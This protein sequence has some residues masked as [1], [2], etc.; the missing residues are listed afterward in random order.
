[1]KTLTY[2][3]FLSFCFFAMCIVGN[4]QTIQMEDVGGVYKI[5][6]IVNGLR[7]KMIFDPGASTVCI[8]ES[9]AVMMLE[10]EYLSINDIKGTGQSQVADGSIV[11][12][13]KIN[14]KKVQIGDKVLNNIEAVVIHGQDAPLLFGQSALR[15]LGQY[16]ISGNKLIIGTSDGGKE[17]ALTQKEIDSI[18]SIA[19]DAA[20]KGYYNVA[21]EQYKILYDNDLLTA[22]GK[23]IYAS[24]IESSENYEDA[25]E[26]FLI[27]QSE[28]ITDFPEEKDDLFFN[29][30][31]CYYMLHDY[32][33]AIPFFEKARYNTSDKWGFIDENSV[34]WTM[35]SYREMGDVYKAKQVIE[36]YIKEYLL[37][38]G[39]NNTDCWQLHKKDVFLAGLYHLRCYA[40]NDYEKTDFEYYV[41]LSAAWGNDKA[42]KYCNEHNISYWLE[43][44][45]HRYQ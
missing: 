8:S 1:M 2:K 6:C 27:I 38:K 33:N 23:K 24:F 13:K 30:G 3:L 26:L 16:T 42:K 15:K 7:L 39:L 21:V 25:L 41:I 22:A 36:R 14:L 19:F 12:H 31:L 18:E 9:T 4:A 28:I 20:S 5:P 44:N 45:K 35:C 11:D 43:S 32:G 34:Y 37:E 29:I 40:S 17:F 10:N